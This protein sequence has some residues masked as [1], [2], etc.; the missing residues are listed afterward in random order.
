MFQNVVSTSENFHK[1]WVVSEYDNLEAAL[2]NLE[3][4][5]AQLKKRYLKW[6]KMVYPAYYA[7][8]KREE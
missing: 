6:W 4:D 2:S 5:V 7:T 3:N 1:Y 8:I